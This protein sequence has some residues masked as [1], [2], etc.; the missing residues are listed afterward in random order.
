MS[1]LDDIVRNLSNRIQ[2]VDLKDSF[3]N[4][5]QGVPVYTVATLPAAGQAGR[6][7]YVSDTGKLMYDTG[8]QWRSN[9]ARFRV[10]PMNYGPDTPSGATEAAYYGY[11]IILPNS[12][13]PICTASVRM[14]EDWIPGTPIII[15]AFVSSSHTGA[16]DFSTFAGS[17]AYN[18]AW[19]HNI[20]AGTLSSLTPTG[21]DFAD[22]VAYTYNDADIQ[23][24]RAL[25]FN[26]VRAAATDPN[27]GVARIGPVYMYYQ[28]DM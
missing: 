4:V 18:T 11:V 8:T 14:P 2:E 1:A 25:E 12:G 16:I 21:I 6:V 20:D 22:Y 10:V 24:G 5:S 19:A 27:T 26:L 7:A 23:A 9:A 17:V 28:A 3:A 13:S 15:I